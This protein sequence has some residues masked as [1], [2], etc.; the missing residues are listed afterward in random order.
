MG[1]E[2]RAFSQ[3]VYDDSHVPKRQSPESIELANRLDQ[4]TITTLAMWELIRDQTS[5][6][7]EDLIAKMQEVDLR[8][9]KKD[10]KLVLGVKTC[11][12]C[13]RPANPRH[14]KCLY[15]GATFEKESAFEG[16]L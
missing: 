9:G 14:T 5:L 2:I 12:A 4:L 15:C 8:D 6:T 3:M 16:A 1:Q 13:N 7:E 10:G 11:S